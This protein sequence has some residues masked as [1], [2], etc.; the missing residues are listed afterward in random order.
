L[1]A[2]GGIEDIPLVRERIEAKDE[3]RAGTDIVADYEI[4]NSGSFAPRPF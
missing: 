4:A 2:V 1:I 3:L